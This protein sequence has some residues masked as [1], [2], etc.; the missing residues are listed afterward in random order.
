ML[1]K[2]S[3]AC[4]AAVGKACTDRIFRRYLIHKNEFSTAVD[5]FVENDTHPMWFV[6]IESA[7]CTVHFTAV[8][9][10]FTFQK[11]HLARNL[12]LFFSK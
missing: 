10:H 4:D 7:P 1:W 8:R 9:M 12:L 5:N 3:G 6:G 11:T 2:R